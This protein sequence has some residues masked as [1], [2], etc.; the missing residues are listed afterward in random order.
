MSLCAA[1]GRLVAGVAPAC[2]ACVS[3][4]SQSSYE[5]VK[6]QQGDSLMPPAKKPATRRTSRSTARSTTRQTTRRQVEQATKR[7]EKALDQ[8]STAL[9]AL[10]KDAGSGAKS[11]YGDVTK[12]LRTLQTD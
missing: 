11:A 4:A 2:F 9:Q 3:C 7:F 8:A 6:A 12:A 10:A 5:S 1:R